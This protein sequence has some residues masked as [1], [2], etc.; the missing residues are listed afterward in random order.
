M[1]DGDA[2][3]RAGA[4][5]VESNEQNEWVKAKTA[6]EREAFLRITLDDAGRFV[7][8]TALLGM[9]RKHGAASGVRRFAE[10]YGIG[11]KDSAG[12]ERALQ[13]VKKGILTAAHE[14]SDEM[15]RTVSR[16]DAFDISRFGF[17]KG[18]P[19]V[20]AM[21]AYTCRNAL[22]DEW[23][24]AVRA[25]ATPRE[26]EV[27]VK[28]AISLMVAFQSFWHLAQD[29]PDLMLAV[30]RIDKAEHLKRE[31]QR[32]RGDLKAA[33]AELAQVKGE[34]KVA[35]RA[36]KGSKS[37]AP[38]PARNEGKEGI[39]ALRKENHDLRL[40]IAE[41]E[42][43]LQPE[44][45]ERPEPEPGLF[46][47]EPAEPVLEAAP[48]PSVVQ[49]KRILAVGGD[50]KEDVYR[51]LVEGLGG[52]YA[53]MSGFRGRPIDKDDVAGFDAVIFVATQ[54]R[55]NVFDRVKEHAK[56][57]GIPYRILTFKG[58]EAFQAAL[59]ECCSRAADG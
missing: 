50:S 32:L 14:F 58:N 41:L 4:E 28:E 40:R 7:A 6:E 48:D 54:M 57:L 35:L 56:A 42:R 49:G 36:A 22:M 46:D 18:P 31:N 2:E 30:E 11:L 8:L 9:M 1:V 12:P 10:R 39:R 47:G 15:D 37:A 34:L 27:P 16:G 53:F 59:V 55:H 13:R 23:E 3:D 45:E 33:R 24:E 19:E 17:E 29:L 26:G 5:E 44:P 38:E 25:F 52:E 21:M 20:L 51:D 43:E